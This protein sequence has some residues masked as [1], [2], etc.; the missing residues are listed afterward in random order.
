[1]RHV[2]SNSTGLQNALAAGNVVVQTGATPGTQQSGRQHQCQCEFFLV[3]RNLADLSAFNSINFATGV[4]ATNTGG[5]SV[6]LR[7]D[8]TG[9]GGVSG[10]GLNAGF[11]QVTFAGGKQIRL[12][13][14]GA[15]PGNI[16][17]YTTGSRGGRLREADQRCGQ[18][19]ARGRR[20]AD[21]LRA[22]Q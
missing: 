8:N 11:G 4:T 9:I 18:C 6:T 22:R 16:R 13:G 2:A 21:P 3:D 17:F 10:A 20:Q 12:S 5:G 1:M 15:T 19:L 14:G 7:A